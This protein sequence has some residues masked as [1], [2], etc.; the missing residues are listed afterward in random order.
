MARDGR[1]PRFLAHVHPK[2][3][4]PSRAILLIAAIN[5][6]T[7]LAFANQLEMASTLVCLAR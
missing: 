2:R 7:G 1:L 5:L 3:R 4:I 6:V